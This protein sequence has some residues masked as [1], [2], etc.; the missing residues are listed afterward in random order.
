MSIFDPKYRIVLIVFFWI[1]IIASLL[2]FVGVV[3]DYVHNKTIEIPPKDWLILI[4]CPLL[5][6]LDILLIHGLKGI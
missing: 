6:I 3:Y 5:I 1:S 2:L 4:G